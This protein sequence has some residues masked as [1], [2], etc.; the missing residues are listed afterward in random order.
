MTKQDV[1]EASMSKAKVDLNMMSGLLAKKGSQVEPASD[2]VQRG[3]SSIAKA[4]K[5]KPSKDEIV[6]LSFKVPAEFRKRFKLA[7]IEEGITQNE[8]VQRLL[9]AWE[10]QAQ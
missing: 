3:S 2:A 1:G 10:S 7:A 5:M 6:N 4:E 9:E 8:L